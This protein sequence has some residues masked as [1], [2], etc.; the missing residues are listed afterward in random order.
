MAETVDNRGPVITGF[1]T[2]LPPAEVDNSFFTKLNIGSSEQWVTEMTGIEN[3]HWATRNVATSDLATPAARDALAM[4]GLDPKQLD[5][6]VVATATADYLFPATA[7]IVQNNLG[8]RGSA[9]DLE[10][11]CSG[12]IY[13]LQHAFGMQRGGEKEKSLVIGAENLSAFL[14]LRDRATCVLFGDGGSAFVVEKKENP[15][16]AK[17]VTD[18]DGTGE[19]LIKLPAGGSRNP[20]THKTIDDR[21]HYVHMMREG[22]FKRAVRAMTS[23]CDRVLQKADL[24]P[25]KVDWVIPHQANI[26]IMDAV[27]DK[28]GV[29]KEKRVS[30]INRHG[31]TSAASIPLALHCAFN[32]GRI[33]KDD[34]LLLVAFGSGLTFAGAV[35]QWMI[36]NPTPRPVKI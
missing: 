25:D 15:G 24:T 5:E 18:A 28:F 35:I 10:A 2:Y 16:L 31:N 36:D 11:A 23:M 4:A 30:F 8:A 20:A 3:R 32:E 13:A 22:T 17:F 6:I 27:W 21:D 12:T 7:C 14:D 9:F 34:I 26:R 29:P 19:D 1:G 33:Q